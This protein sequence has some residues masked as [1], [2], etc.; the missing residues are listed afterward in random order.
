MTEPN[1]VPSPAELGW[2]AEQLGVSAESSAEA[3]RSAFLRELE[4]FD[5]VPPEPVQQA[6]H[7]LTRRAPAPLVAA[8]AETTLRGEVEAFAESFFTLPCTERQ[9]QWRDLNARAETFPAVKARLQQ[10]RLGLAISP[11]VRDP[12]PRVRQLAGDVCALF[13]L[14]PAE[15]A[16][17]RQ[18]LRRGWLEH[19][20]PW[21]DA[22]RALQRR[23]PATADLEP[24]LV[25]WLASW[26]FH[27][28]RLALRRLKQPR[29]P[30]A[31]NQPAAN[32]AQDADGWKGGFWLAVLVLGIIR[33]LISL[34]GSGSS[35]PRYNLPN[36][37]NPTY[38]PWEQPKFFEDSEKLRKVLQDLKEHQKRLQ[39]ENG[40]GPPIRPRFPWL[41]DQ[42]PAP[43]P[44]D[45]GSK[46]PMPTRKPPP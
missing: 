3:V 21:E 24:D 23:H 5:F 42:P 4:P 30:P 41:D 9:S 46:Q 43:D 29:V 7:A 2:A 8:E 26:D 19:M 31:Q 18:A 10:L 11:E 37:P 15:R 34:G 1:R 27:Q 33:L 20:S 6:F 45:R 12:E 14:R 17:R 40:Q 44:D 36:L 38:R 32:P 28:Q 13:V 16:Q 22:A 35:T 25:S 39:E